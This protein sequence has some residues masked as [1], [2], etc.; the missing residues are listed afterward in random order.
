[1]VYYRILNIVP[2]AELPSSLSHHLPCP[3]G[4]RCSS[5]WGFCPS[6]FFPFFPSKPVAVRSG[7][8]SPSR[9]GY[10]HVTSTLL[11]IWIEWPSNTGVLDNLPL[12]LWS[13]CLPGHT[14]HAH[15]TTT[16]ILCGPRRPA[17]IHIPYPSAPNSCCPGQGMD[18]PT[19][20]PLQGTGQPLE[21]KWVFFLLF[22]QVDLISLFP[23]TPSP[24]ASLGCLSGPL[25]D[26][27]C[28]TESLGASLESDPS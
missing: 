19:R 12:T 7:L 23:S 11:L 25:S 26:F 17:V 16:F 2:C 22:L 18:P 20:P 8:W 1:M 10:P 5:S 24:R 13:L 9:H 14:G 3:G 6:R 27:F 15:C 4:G 21:G 28:S